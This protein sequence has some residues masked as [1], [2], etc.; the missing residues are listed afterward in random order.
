MSKKEIYLEKAQAVIQEQSE[1]LE[2]LK[3]RMKVEVADKKTQTLEKIE[4]LETKLNTAKLRIIDVSEAAEDAWE[5]LTER[6]DN[7][8]DEV[9]ESLKKFFSK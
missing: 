2:K 4:K 8:A 1:K 9:G 7:L 3:A 5:D 6:F